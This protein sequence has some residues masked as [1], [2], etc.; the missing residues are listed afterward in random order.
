MSDPATAAAAA[1][2]AAAASAP[3]IQ[4]VAGRPKLPTVEKARMKQMLDEPEVQQEL[5]RLVGGNTSAL[6]PIIGILKAVMSSTDINSDPQ[7][8]ELLK[9]H[10]V[11]SC[12]PPSIGMQRRL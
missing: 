6:Q 2:A 7:M 4:G 12:A 9:T 8:V 1:A 11:R 5:A 3:Q 10:Q